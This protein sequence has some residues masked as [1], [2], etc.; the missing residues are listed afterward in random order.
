MVRLRETH[1][2]SV[3]L[4]HGIRRAVRAVG[5]KSL[6]TEWLETVPLKPARQLDPAASLTRLLNRTQVRTSDGR[7][8]DGRA[9]L[10]ALHSVEQ[11]LQL[12]HRE[13]DRLPLDTLTKAFL[14]LR[15]L[16]CGRP[17]S[18]G[19]E[20]LQRLLEL[21]LA[22]ECVAAK[23]AGSRGGKRHG[24]ELSFGE[25]VDTSVEEPIGFANRLSS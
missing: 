6:Q 19:L 22:R 11:A 4:L 16:R 20:A 18:H 17:R 21:A 24:D 9:A 7:S 5:R 15:M 10:R 1:Q 25:F 13:F 2:W 14:Q 12:G 3:R 23:N 8:R